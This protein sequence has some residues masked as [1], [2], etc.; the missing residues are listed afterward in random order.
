MTAATTAHAH[1]HPSC[2]CA[3]AECP[4]R[5]RKIVL[6]GG[7]EK[8]GG[9][10]RIAKVKVRHTRGEGHTGQGHVIGVPRDTRLAVG[11]YPQRQDCI[12]IVGLTIKRINRPKKNYIYVTVLRMLS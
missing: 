8:V 3:C 7:Q 11:V 5:T 1:S 6:Y 9:I 10:G 2:S 12:G 4:A